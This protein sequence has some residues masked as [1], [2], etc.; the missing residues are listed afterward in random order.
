[1]DISIGSS[2]S[3]ISL[4]SHCLL[5]K[6]QATVVRVVVRFC[7]IEVTEHEGKAYIFIRDNLRRDPRIRELHHLVHLNLGLVS[8]DKVS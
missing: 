2:I 6:Y 7:S 3:W 5:L 4:H 8:E 1:M